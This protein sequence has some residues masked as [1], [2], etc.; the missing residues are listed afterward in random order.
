MQTRELDPALRKLVRMERQNE[1][2]MKDRHTS[3]VICSLIYSLGGVMADS[4]DMNNRGRPP[5]G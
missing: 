4:R 5:A 1:K 3:K 2:D